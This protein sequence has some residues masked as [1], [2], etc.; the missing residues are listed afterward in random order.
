MITKNIK[1]VLFASLLVAM[2]L[3]FSG[4]IN[5]TA[6]T[7][8]VNSDELFAEF[9]TLANKT[10]EIQNLIDQLEHE[11]ED[12]K[13]EALQKQLTSIQNKMDTLQQQNIDAVKMNPGQLKALEK[14][15]DALLKKFTNPNSPFY[16][17]SASTG[18]FI[19]QIKQRP[20]FTFEDKVPQFNANALEA[21]EKNGNVYKLEKTPFTL[22][23]VENNSHFINCSEREANCNYA[24]GGIAIKAGGNTSTLGFS[25]VQSHGHSGFV[26][27]EHGVGGYGTIVDQYPTRDVG[28]VHAKSSGVCDCAF[29]ERYSNIAAV[30]KVYTGPS[31]TSSIT[32]YATSSNPSVG[33]WLMMTGVSSEVE[34]GTY[35][36]WHPTYQKMASNYSSTFGDSGAPVT[37]IGSGVKLYGMHT[38]GDSSYSYAT[39]YNT[40]KIKL[41]LQ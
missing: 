32:S 3:P 38:S 40:I 30:Y 19:D 6:Q 20:H 31:Q 18:Y 4:M 39:P 8:K 9:I 16:I 34:Y 2:I 27:V 14:R 35:A 5:A 25:A 12:S 24:I 26:T 21:L 37:T 28:T 11:G 22:G 29:I 33:T 17:D 41:G 15:S 36:G 1:I 13:I 7:Q 23:L 10:Q